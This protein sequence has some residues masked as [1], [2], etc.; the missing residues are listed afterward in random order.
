LRF[1]KKKKKHL[2]LIVE[3][4]EKKMTI[5]ETKANKDS[6]ICNVAEIGGRNVFKANTGSCGKVKFEKSMGPI[7][8]GV[9][10]LFFFLAAKNSLFQVQ[11]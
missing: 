10:F 5:N 3:T 6:T 4:E 8:S 1:K 7:R 2:E 11:Q 9:F